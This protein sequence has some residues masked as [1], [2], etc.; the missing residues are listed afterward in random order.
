MNTRKGRVKFKNFRILLDSGFS[1]TI[2]MRRM[3]EKICP[4]KDAVMQWQNQAG[5]ITT[6]FNIKLDFTLPALSATNVVT[7]KC[8]VYDSAR[9]RNDMILCR[10]ILT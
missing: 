10:D 2:V 6:N 8:H 5:N 7:W 9:G 1:F 3:V 4:K